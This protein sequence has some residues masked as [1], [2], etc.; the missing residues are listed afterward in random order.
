MLL[1][2]GDVGA[3]ARGRELRG[4]E[5]VG[6]VPWA[7]Q[8]VDAEGDPPPYSYILEVGAEVSKPVL[9]RPKAVLCLRCRLGFGRWSS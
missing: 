4:R 7:P 8:A 3:G 6:R 5:R 1:G 2:S 9:Q